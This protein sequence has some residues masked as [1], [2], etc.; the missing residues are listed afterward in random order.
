MSELEK[1]APALLDYVKASTELIDTL[2]G[3][4]SRLDNKSKYEFH[5]TDGDIDFFECPHCGHRIGETF[6]GKLKENVGWETEM[7]I[8]QYEVRSRCKNCM[9]RIKWSV[10]VSKDEEE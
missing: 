5:K 8:T 3:A 10:C 1:I 4:V 6:K 2:N 7:G 9:G